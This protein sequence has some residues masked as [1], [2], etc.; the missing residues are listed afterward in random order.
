VPR[1]DRTI[2]ISSIV[3]NAATNNRHD[4]L[5]SSLSNSRL[6]QGGAPP[7]EHEKRQRLFFASTVHDELTTWMVLARSLAS[8]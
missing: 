2:I 8:Y 7:W 1:A 3:T 6:D 4:I 5:F